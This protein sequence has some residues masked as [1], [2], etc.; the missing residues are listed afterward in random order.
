M[1]AGS[2]LSDV[3]TDDPRREVTVVLNWPSELKPATRE[4]NDSRVSIGRSPRARS[5]A[6][7]SQNLCSPAEALTIAVPLRLSGTRTTPR[8]A[9]YLSR[10]KAAIGR[11][12]LP[13]N[14]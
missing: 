8:L 13:L 10:S 6:E 3:L 1:A 9:V 7:T 4:S 14:S 12:A 2:L 11:S 5:A